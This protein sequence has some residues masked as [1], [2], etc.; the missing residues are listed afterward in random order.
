MIK[1]I[2]TCLRSIRCLN[3]NNFILPGRS[4]TLYD[5]TTCVV[6][7]KLKRKRLVPNQKP[8]S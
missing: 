6:K 3:W 2:N 4:D 5:G 8:T 7:S 1:N